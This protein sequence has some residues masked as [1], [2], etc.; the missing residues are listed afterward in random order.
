MHNGTLLTSQYMCPFVHYAL[1]HSVIRSLSSLVAFLSL[2]RSREIC[3]IIQFQFKPEK[4]PKITVSQSTFTFAEVFLLTH[5][6]WPISDCPA[7]VETNLLPALY[8]RI[9]IIKHWHP[10]SM[11]KCPATRATT[12]A[13]EEVRLSSS[14][15]RNVLC[16][17]ISLRGEFIYCPSVSVELPK[18]R[19]RYSPPVQLNNTPW[20]S[21]SAAAAQQWPV[22]K[23]PSSSSSTSSLSLRNLRKNGLHVIA[24]RKAMTTTTC[25][26]NTF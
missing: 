20:S 13:E 9:I 12:Q 21:S 19:G 26:M 4:K 24:F 17:G 11:P 2:R 16:D 10:I 1:T 3:S 8:A 18:I 23:L 25:G 6:P 22:L 7:E 15:L 14:S 5:M